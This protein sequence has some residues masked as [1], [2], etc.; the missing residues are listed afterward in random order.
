MDSYAKFNV[1]NRQMKTLN[2]VI[3]D[4]NP[5]FEK[6]KK[7]AKKDT[8]TIEEYKEA[9]ERLDYFYNELR[10]I[11]KEGKEIK[12]KLEIIQPSWKDYE[13][14]K[15]SLEFQYSN[16]RESYKTA[17]KQIKLYKIYVN[18]YRKIRG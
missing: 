10:L 5:I 18:E 15:N 17:L 12:R 6:L 14:L 4:L 9:K 2:S 3:R 7:H 16:L 13:E 1:W 8:Y 11:E